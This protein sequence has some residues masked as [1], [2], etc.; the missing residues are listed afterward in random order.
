MDNYKVKAKDIKQVKREDEIEEQRLRNVTSKKHRLP[1]KSDYKKIKKKI[2]RAFFLSMGFLILNVGLYM[3]ELIHLFELLPVE[4]HQQFMITSYIATVF[5][6]TLPIV[7]F[8]IE[9][10]MRGNLGY[11]LLSKRRTKYALTK[12]ERNIEFC[13]SFS[14]LIPNANNKVNLDFYTYKTTT[15]ARKSLTQILKLINYYS[16]TVAFK[17]LGLKYQAI[18]LQRIEKYMKELNGA[19]IVAYKGRVPKYIIESFEEIEKE[20]IDLKKCGA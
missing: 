12:V 2:Y 11:I 4:K 14:K 19:V 8:F 18:T 20:M 7:L 15:Y 5:F 1:R 10:I 6:T 3:F 17:A 9:M 13:H 16:N